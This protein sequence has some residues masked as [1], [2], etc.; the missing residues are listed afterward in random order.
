MA[1]T[2]FLNHTCDIYHVQED[3]ASPGYG[4]PS[5]PSFSY[6]DSPDIEGVACHFAVKSFSHS[7]LQTNPANE[8]DARIKLVLPWGTDIRVN[9]R[10]VEPT[11]GYMYTAEIPRKVRTHH[12]F[13][14]VKRLETE[15]AL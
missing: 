5:S 11:T 6:P 8:Y 13:V 10:I 1:W 2:D 15:K 4:L 3:S 14:F 9:D 12:V 7:V